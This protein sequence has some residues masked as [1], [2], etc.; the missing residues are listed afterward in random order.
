[1]DGG[2]NEKFSYKP[3]AGLIKCSLKLYKMATYSVVNRIKPTE[4]LTSILQYDRKNRA[5]FFFLGAIENPLAGL[6]SEICDLELFNSNNFTASDTEIAKANR[7]TISVSI[8]ELCEM[9][10]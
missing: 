3:R 4:N 9:K 6:D 5:I 10:L 8:N 1:M 7:L 2:P